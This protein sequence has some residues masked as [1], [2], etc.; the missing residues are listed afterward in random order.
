MKKN[1]ISPTDDQQLFLR[2]VLDQL[3][4]DKRSEIDERLITDQSLSDAFQE[5]RNDLIDA[6]A[7]DELPADVRLQVEQAILSDREGQIALSMA[8]T[9]KH[10]KT[11]PTIGS[12]TY[13]REHNRY[14]PVH[15]IF[16]GKTRI[17][18]FAASLAACSLLVFLF[19][20][21]R[22]RST[23]QTAQAGPV[24]TLTDVAG[25]TG[26]EGRRTK[27]LA[28]SSNKSSPARHSA[29]RQTNVLAIAMPMETLRGD[30]LI[31]ITLRPGV[32]RIHVQWPIPA[33]VKASA[34]MLEIA[35][36][37][38][39]QDVLP[40]HGPLDRIGN[41]RVA[42]FFVAADKLPTGQ[43]LFRLLI[44]NASEKDPVA[45]SSVRISR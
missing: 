16:E 21:M 38:S 25:S 15:W 40:Q 18:V 26:S 8:R 43:V 5:A 45:E 17:G 41:S 44:A 11:G 31:A 10:L 4:P 14:S 13:R 36:K 34:Y 28:G 42:N 32:D 29:L 9:M 3:H 1:T 37:Q 6:Y 27:N 2:Y 24:S 39:I 23:Y 22:Q 20:H 19:F 30:Q 12:D 33:D 35:S 7:A